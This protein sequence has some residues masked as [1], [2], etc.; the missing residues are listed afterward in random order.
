[1]S[2]TEKRTPAEPAGRTWRALAALGLAA[3]AWVA[4]TEIGGIVAEAT[5]TGGT[6][7]SALFGFARL[8]GFAD[9]TPTVQALQAWS[10]PANLL[11]QYPAPHDLYL[12]LFS[13][14]GFDLL[15]LI[16]YG[17]FGFALLRPAYNSLSSQSR[18]EP[19]LWLLLIDR[20]S[21]V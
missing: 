19:A 20:K 8:T 7:L 5:P 17:L 16:G 10:G 11:N 18:R 14:L 1:M 6:S 21:V 3:A 2:K 4:M 12:W 15:F 9:L 13:Y